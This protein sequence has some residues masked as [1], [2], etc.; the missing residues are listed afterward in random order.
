MC[1]QVP[2]PR[3][4]VNWV[5]VGGPPAQLHAGPLV[6]VVVVV[7]VVVGVAV[8]VVVVVV[9]VVVVVVVVVG[10]CVVVVV[11]AVTVVVVVVVAG[12]VVVVV[13]V[14]G[15]VVVV[16][17]VVLLVV[18]VVDVVGVTCW[19]ASGSQTPEPMFLPPRLSQP[20]AERCSHWTLPR[21]L[22]SSSS[23]SSFSSV[24]QQRIL[25]GCGQ[26]LS[27]QEPLPAIIMPCWS[28]HLS[29]VSILHS[30][31]FSS[32]SRTQHRTRLSLS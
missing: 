17:V 26:V 9:G 32:S 28:W 23:S 11:V 10:V 2:E 19:Q 22:S 31:S 30:L 15:V 8:V 25:P 4:V 3:P 27:S 1:P 29:A 7:V 24:T 5:L 14:V 20:L 12:V 6:V 21:S 16:V 18:V 13:V